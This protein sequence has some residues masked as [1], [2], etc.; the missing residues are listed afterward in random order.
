MVVTTA[1]GTTMAAARAR[2]AGA[3]WTTAAMAG[4]AAMAATAVTMM[5]NGEK[6]NE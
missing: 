6:D 5:P 1:R 3:T 2:G 4:T